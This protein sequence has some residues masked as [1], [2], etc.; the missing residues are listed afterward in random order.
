[1]D[2]RRSVADPVFDAA[3]TCSASSTCSRPRRQRRRASRCS[4]PRP[5]APS[6]ASRDAFPPPR[7]TRPEPL[8]PYG[9]SKRTGEHYLLLLPGACTACRTS[10]CATPTSTA[11]ARIRTARPAWSRSSASKLLRGEPH[12]DQRRRQAD[13]R[14][15]VRRRRRAR[16]PRRAR[17]RR[18]AARSTSAPASRPTSTR[19]SRPARRRPAA[20]PRSQHGPAKA[21]E[22]RRSVIDARRAAEVLGWQPRGAAARRPGAD[23][24]VLPV[25]GQWRSQVRL[26]RGRRRPP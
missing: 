2:V 18:Y 25:R 20:G 16:Q 8:S 5:A 23:G 10:R 13:A 7:R 6:T 24:R 19:S 15:R 22:Q 17:R 3:S 4:S 9:V 12:G 1:M 21:G 14:L 26:S 11:R